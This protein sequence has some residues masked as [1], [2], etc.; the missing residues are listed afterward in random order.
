[1]DLATFVRSTLVE[2]AHGIQQANKSLSDERAKPDATFQLQ[3]SHGSGNHA[4]EPIEFDVA[5]VVSEKEESSGKGGLKVA[6]IEAG[7]Q[8]SA[9]SENQTTSRVKFHVGVV[10]TVMT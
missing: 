6:W 4:H 8:K 5:V 9:T 3:G 10:W 7:G 1:M 2:I